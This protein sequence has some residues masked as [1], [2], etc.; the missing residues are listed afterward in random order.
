MFG[1]D[2]RERMLGIARSAIESAFTGESTTIPETDIYR[3]A[4]VTLHKNNTLR[5]CIGYLEGVAPLYR[6]IFLL[7]REAAFNDYRFPPLEKEELPLISIEISVLTVPERITDL[8]DFHLGKDG[9]IMSLGPRRAVFLP[10]VADETGWN[11]SQMLTALSR[12]AGLPPDAWHNPEAVF[13][14]FQAEV[15][16][17]SDM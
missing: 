7:S 10:Q 11:K 3:G 15:F 9:I 12:K 13:M 16:S 17:E 2:E 14:T 6:Q 4:F 5:G 8:N 1:K